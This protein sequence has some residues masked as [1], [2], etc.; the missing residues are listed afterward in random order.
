MLREKNG[1]EQNKE[2]CSCSVLLCSTF[3]RFHGGRTNIT[4][5][6][7]LFLAWAV[8]LPMLLH[9]VDSITSSWKSSASGYA[10][11]GFSP[12][13]I[14]L[15]FFFFSSPVEFRMHCNMALCILYVEI[16]HLSLSLFFYWLMKKQRL[17][18][19]CCDQPT[20]SCLQLVLHPGKAFAHDIVLYVCE[21]ILFIKI[22]SGHPCA[23]GM[24][25]HCGSHWLF[26]FCT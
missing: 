15:L 5:S 7:L 18:T 1:Q 26:F 6:L 22:W 9:W 16:Q 20:Y 2:V 24:L 25:A 17:P 21:R 23:H 4:F 19:Y 10:D 14:Q 12:A 3:L 8:K 11:G 13:G